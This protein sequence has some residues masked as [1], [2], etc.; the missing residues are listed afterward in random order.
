MLRRG[1]LLQKKLEERMTDLEVVSRYNKRKDPSQF[2]SN[3][4]S[5]SCIKTVAERLKGIQ[6]S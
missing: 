6:L 5:S 3:S 1:R 2:N 4:N